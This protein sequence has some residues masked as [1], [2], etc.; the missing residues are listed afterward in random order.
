M[1]HAFVIGLVN[2]LDSEQCNSQSKS[3]ISIFY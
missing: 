1:D 3:L 2:E